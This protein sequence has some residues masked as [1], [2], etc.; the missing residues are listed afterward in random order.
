MAT[1]VSSERPKVVRVVSAR[2]KNA[3]KVKEI[4]VSVLWT[5]QGG[6]L[7]LRALRH[8]ARYTIMVETLFD[9]LLWADAMRQVKEKRSRRGR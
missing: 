1:R 2:P 5:P 8:K 3:H 6:M 7:E 4:A 9:R